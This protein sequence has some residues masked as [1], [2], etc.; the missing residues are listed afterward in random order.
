MRVEHLPPRLL[1]ARDQVGRRNL[2]RRRYRQIRVADQFEPLQRRV[3]DGRGTVDRDPAKLDLR[4]RRRLR[5]STEPEGQRVR[6]GRARGADRRIL[7]KRVIGEHFIDNQGGTSR[8]APRVEG[9]LFRRRQHGA[10]GIVGA[11][12]EDRPRAG[13]P[14][15]VH[16]ARVQPPS[17]IVIEAV[18]TRRD[19]VE[20]RQVL[21]QRIAG[22]RHQDRVATRRARQLEQQRVCLARAR[23]QDDAIRGD[24]KTTPRVIGGH[25][26]AR[27]RQPERTRLIV[28]HPRGGQRSEQPLRDNGCPRWWGC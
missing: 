15:L 8:S 23:R 2:G 10:G 14:H 20:R 19:A 6:C 27:A 13:L 22:R 7:R 9:R 12:G 1:A 5:Q 17:S 26:L 11:D 18:G 21:E 16:A 3:D 4:Q 25:R 24:A 28:G